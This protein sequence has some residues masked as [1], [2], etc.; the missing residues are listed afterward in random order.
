M[1]HPTRTDLLQ[2]KEKAASVANSTAILKARRQ[3]LIRGFL[4]SVRP[5]V[6]SRDAIRRDYSA[7]LGELHLGEGHEGM[8]LIESIAATAEREL[9]VDVE[10]RNAMGVRYRDL[11]VYGP[12]VRSPEDR[13]Y[14]YAVTTPHLEESVHLFERVLESM[15]EIAAFE[16]K[17]K[18]LGAEILHVT[19]R[20]RVLEER[21]L[22]R[23]QAEIRTIVQYL[24]EREREAHFRLKKFKDS[25]GRRSAGSGR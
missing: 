15:L 16:S 24:G 4:E 14:G 6:R 12:F 3:A 8:A 5:F 9:G 10:E 21:V 17:L 18:M 11:A 23:L 22:P 25:R 20:T 13:D 1:I 2:L 19:R 7:A